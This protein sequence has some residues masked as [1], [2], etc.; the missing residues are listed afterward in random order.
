[1]GVLHKGIITPSFIE[2]A[3]MAVMK[4]A[5]LMDDDDEDGQRTPHHC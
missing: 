1:M 2:I 3:L 5:L 4:R